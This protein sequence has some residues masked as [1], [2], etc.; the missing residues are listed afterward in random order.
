MNFEEL[1]KDVVEPDLC[2]R[3]GICV[4][5]CPVGVIG[6]GRNNF[7]V[8][9]GECIDCGFCVKSCPGAEVN[10]PLLSQQ[11]FN[12]DYD[13]DN[14]QGRVEKV[15][16]AHAA[17]DQ[18][19]STG[20]SGGLV[21]A[22]L[23]YLLNSKAIDGAVVAGFD[24]DDPCKIKGILATT[25]EE[26]VDAAKS[27]YC[28]SSTM[29]A[30]QIVRRKKGRFAV[31]GLPCQV[32]GLRK[33]IS[34]DPSLGEKISCI[35]G[36]YCHCNMEPYVQLDILKNRCIKPSDI[37]RFNFRG[38]GWPGGFH[39]V[40]KDGTEVSLHSTLYTTVLN[41]LFK[42][43]GAPRCYLCV[44]ALSEYA[45]ISFGDFW[46]QDYPG[47]FHKLERCTLVSQRTEKGKEILQKAEQ[48]GAITVYH[49]PSGRYSKRIINMARGKKSRN[50][51][52]IARMKKKGQ[53]VPEYHFP[54]PTPSRKA[55]LRELMLRLSFLLRG[56]FARKMLLKFLFSKAAK[57]FER[58]NLYR[59]KMFCNYHGN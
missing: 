4:G 2:T 5:V 58:V 9:N 31:V 57:G 42:I 24:S 34:C 48:D 55:R 10:F 11:V 59:K 13:P 6:L 37:T 46:A 52:R 33:L 16:V 12:H 18:I 43:Y 45:D 3:C 30:L 47:D 51:A 22:L 44:D 14:L 39:V 49:L 41:V 25:P 35:F 20:T 36:L 8:L 19:R 56:S 26:I 29:D 7:P 15:F 32:Q 53:Q 1:Y 17:D 54:V 23:V 50:L 28:I 38:G 27:K 40:K 21:T